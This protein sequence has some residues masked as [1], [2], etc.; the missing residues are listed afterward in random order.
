[1]KKNGRL[2]IRLPDELK[3][4]ALEYTKS[5]H[6]TVSE[7]ITRF[8]VRLREEEERKHHPVDAEQI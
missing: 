7:L 3:K 8:L 1:M 4:W 2:Q 5:R 6:T